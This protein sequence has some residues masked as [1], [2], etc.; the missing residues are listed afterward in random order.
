MKF[1][2]FMNFVEFVKFEKFVVPY[3][4]RK[5]KCFILFYWF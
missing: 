3:D 4:F 1:V 2:K 5:I